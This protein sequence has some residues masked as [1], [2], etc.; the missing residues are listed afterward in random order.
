M[1]RS[2]LSGAPE[3]SDDVNI[4]NSPGNEIFIR[5]VMGDDIYVYS[6]WWEISAQPLMLTASV[7]LC[8]AVLCNMHGTT[9]KLSFF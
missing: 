1:I 5:A 9:T 7:T 3:I 2:Q 4:L 6:L 8:K